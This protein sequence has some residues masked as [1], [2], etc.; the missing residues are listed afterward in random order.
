M[1][2][3]PNHLAALSAILRCG[4]FEQAAAEL[5]VTPSAISQR[6]KAL[7]EKVGS[8]LILRGSPC[9]GTEIGARLAKHAE[10]VGMLETQLSRDLKLDQGQSPMRLRIAVNADSLATWF[11]PALA[12]VPDVS[13]ELVID[14]QNHSA[15]WLRRGEV[16]AA[17]TATGKPVTGCDSLPLGALRSA[18]FGHGLAEIHRALVSRWPNRRRA[19]PGALPDL[20]CQ[21][22]PATAVDRSGNRPQAVAPH[23]PS[24]VNTGVCRRRPGRDWLGH[25]SRKSGAWA[26]PKWPP[27]GSEPGASS[28]HPARLADQPDHGP[29]TETADPGGARGSQR[30]SARALTHPVWR[31]SHRPHP[32]SA[33]Q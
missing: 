1:Q 23:P 16:S 24:A 15:D 28:G 7:E 29:G 6:I 8:A 10:D 25:E 31:P 21:G 33:C 5:A 18:L 26:D 19:G 32:D 9:T 12:A 17:V 30:R 22:Q 3:D 11:L 27:G 13:F 4:S 14:D 2:F 20:Q